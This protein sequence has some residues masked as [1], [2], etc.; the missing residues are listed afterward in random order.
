MLAAV[1]ELR[2][3][4]AL[5]PDGQLRPWIHFCSVKTPKEGFFE[6]VDGWVD[7]LGQVV[8]GG[9]F[10]VVLLRF[11][12]ILLKKTW[13][14]GL[15]PGESA[16]MGGWMNLGLRQAVRLAA[17]VVEQ[18][19][20]GAGEAEL[21]AWRSVR[22]DVHKGPVCRVAAVPLPNAGGADPQPS[23]CC[24]AYRAAYVWHLFFARYRLPPWAIV[25]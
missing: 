5:G 8:V 20:A 11:F 3:A 13:Q 10:F 19:P 12:L 16:P 18:L 2:T 7:L 21:A 9:C 25:I 24:G 6:G 17:P 15:G 1:P 14:V 22:L 4:F 23:R